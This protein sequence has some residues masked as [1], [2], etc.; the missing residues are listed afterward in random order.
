MYEITLA[1]DANR[2]TD[3]LVARAE[4]EITP[5][6]EHVREQYTSTQI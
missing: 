6:L 1:A 3:A 4:Y 2:V 5:Y